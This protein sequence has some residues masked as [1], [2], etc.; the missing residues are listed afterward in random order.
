MQV[1]P[2]RTK[3]LS[4][5]AL[6]TC[7]YR[8]VFGCAHAFRF[9]P[10]RGVEYGWFCYFKSFTLLFVIFISIPFFRHDYYFTTTLVPVMFIIGFACEMKVKEWG[11]DI[12]FLFTNT[13]L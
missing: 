8:G 5:V 4:T 10:N 7:S 9:W 11:R 1:S 13:R 6:V 2:K 3:Q 12:T